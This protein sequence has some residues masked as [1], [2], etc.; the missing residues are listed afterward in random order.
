MDATEYKKGTEGL[1]E[2][3]ISS[4]PTDSCRNQCKVAD[5]ISEYYHTLRDEE[6]SPRYLTSDMEG[7]ERF[8]EQLKENKGIID[9]YAGEATRDTI[10]SY[11]PEDLSKMESMISDL[12]MK[13]FFFKELYSENEYYL[14][15]AEE[16][17]ET[18][19]SLKLLETLEKEGLSGYILDIYEPIKFKPI[20]EAKINPKDL[21]KLREHG[22]ITDTIKYRSG[23]VGSAISGYS[24][25][26]IEDEEGEPYVK[27]TIK[28]DRAGSSLKWR[29]ENKE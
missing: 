17:L 8:V 3:I 14:K 27:L 26:L 2:C 4:I 18:T 7:L 28:G 29:K 22:L 23:E 11:K 24:E 13:C 16:Q 20:P 12:G 10:S 19:P 15:E 9:R 1:T 21:R 5:V 6:L 25:V